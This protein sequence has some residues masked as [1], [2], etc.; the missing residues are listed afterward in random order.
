MPPSGFREGTPGGRP[1][2]SR[3]GFSIFA[4]AP[5]VIF[6]CHLHEGEGF[7]SAYKNGAKRENLDL[8]R[9]R[10]RFRQRF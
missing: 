4:A 7:I 2:C 8:R 5:R 6:L 9:C 3:T 10:P 1:P